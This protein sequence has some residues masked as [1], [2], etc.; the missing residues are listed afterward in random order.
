MYF[1]RILPLLIHQKLNKARNNE[2]LQSDRSLVYGTISESFAALESC[3]ATWFD[4][5]LPIYLAGIQDEYEQARQNAVFGLGELMLYS[6]EKAFA[7]YTPVLQALSQVVAVETHFGTLD[8]VCG[9]LA[10]L[11]IANSQLVPLDHV[12]P[13]FVSKLPLREDYHENK[14]VFKGFHGLLTQN[15]EAFL[16]HL[17]QITLIGL[18]VLGKNE[19]KDDGKCESNKIIALIAMSITSRP[20]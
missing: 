1:G 16:K 5:L 3:S 14:A 4:E 6:E 7:Q 8:N 17:N 13:V 15:S 20:L 19:Y 2:D 10:R 9:A 11:I 12:L 18:H